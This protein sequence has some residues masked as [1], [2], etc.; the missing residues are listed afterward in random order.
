LRFILKKI[1]NLNRLANVIDHP[2]A[3][4]KIVKFSIV[5]SSNYYSQK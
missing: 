5:M 1:P 2:K 3:N 4:R